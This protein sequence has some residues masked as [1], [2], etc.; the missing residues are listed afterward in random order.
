MTNEKESICQTVFYPLELYR[1]YCT[2]TSIATEVESPALEQSGAENLGIL[3]TAA[4][5]DEDTKTITLA[6]INRHPTVAV[7]TEI[8]WKGIKPNSIVEI[9]ELTADSYFAFNDINNPKKE[10]VKY[11]R[12]EINDLKMVTFEPASINILNYKIH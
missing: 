8:E 12:K 11:R 7:E 9:H 4:S 6:I 2:G 5:Y 1:K 10:V 3:D